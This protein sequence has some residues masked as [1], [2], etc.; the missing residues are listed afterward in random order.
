MTVMQ[1]M[2]W[3][4]IMTLAVATRIVSAG[5][6][7]LQCFRQQLMHHDGRLLFDSLLGKSCHIYGATYTY[8]SYVHF[9]FMLRNLQ[10][11]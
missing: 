6:D 5:K 10:C 2:K 1:M 11:P 3:W 4:S 8:L 9:L 7:G